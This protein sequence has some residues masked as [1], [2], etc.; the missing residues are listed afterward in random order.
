M[1]AWNLDQPGKPD[2]HV[3]QTWCRELA[4]WRQLRTRLAGK[5]GNSKK[6]CKNHCLFIMCLAIFEFSSPYDPK[7]PPTC[8]LPEPS[9]GPYLAILG[10][11]WPIQ[12]HLE[13]NM[14]SKLLSSSPQDHKKTSKG[15]FCKLSGSSLLPSS[16]VTVLFWIAMQK[17]QLPRHQR[18]NAP[19]HERSGLVRRNARSD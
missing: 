13:A 10:S 5:L 1:L 2:L 9:L 4:C 3:N 17:L 6:H 14:L 8:K 15:P 7:L 12:A 18:T 11:T 16:L 19:I